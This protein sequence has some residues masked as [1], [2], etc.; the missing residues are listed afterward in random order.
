MAS[1]VQPVN[2]APPRSL[3][4]RAL[5]AY[6]AATPVFAALDLALHLNLRVSFFEHARGI[7]IGYYVIACV[8][9]LLVARWP[10]RAALVGFVE[11]IGN[12]ALLIIGVFV[13]YLGALDAALA[14]RALP[15]TP[16]SPAAVL[17]LVVSA[18]A[19]LVS[20]LAAQARVSRAIF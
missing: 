16:F 1:L 7:R 9:A 14:E 17:N 3:A 20:Y 12:I 5:L 15:T 18:S 8:C 13:A 11:S 4:G 19:L 2:G 10:A 6:Y